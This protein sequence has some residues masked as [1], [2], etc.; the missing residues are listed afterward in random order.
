MGTVVSYWCSQCHLSINP[1][2]DLIF[3]V[4]DMHY[5]QLPIPLEILAVRYTRTETRHH[6]PSGTS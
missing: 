1:N 2:L 3:I 4:W 6:Q 5:P